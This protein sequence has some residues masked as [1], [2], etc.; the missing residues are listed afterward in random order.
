[1]P[2]I[3]GATLNALFST[4]L[5][6]PASV[7]GALAA[8]FV[9]LAVMALRRAGAGGTQRLLMTIAVMAAGALTLISVLDQ[10]TLDRNAAERRALMQRNAE[11]NVSA[12]APGSVLSCLDGG[13]GEAIETACEKS[14]FANPE[15]AAAAVA[16]TAARLM[17][18]A[19][20]QAVAK[21]GE[22]AVIDA[23]AAARR[24][25]ELDRYGIAAHVL[26]TRDGCTAERCAVFALLR[27]T[28]V[29]KANLK[30][31]AF[32]TYVGRYAAAWNK[33]QAVVEKQPAPSSAPVASAVESETSGHP[34]SSRYDFP[35]ANSIPAVSIMNAEP[36]LPKTAAEAQA[37]PPK[38]ESEAAV[39]VPPKKRPQA[40]AATPP[41][42]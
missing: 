24:A 9:V 13:A 36:A 33:S 4:P 5:M 23:F 30:A 31:Q 10:L 40:Q 12:V 41:A 6:L 14:V 2:T 25:L 29:L 16:Y 21:G 34:V 27:D 7:A 11:L 22:P 28:A 17:L 39:P 15:S 42:R 18:L 32:D 8:L 38:P 26:A 3:D 20:A 19:D 35:S 37:A 1:M